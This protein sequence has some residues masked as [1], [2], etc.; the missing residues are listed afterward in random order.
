MLPRSLVDVSIIPPRVRYCVSGNSA[1][2]PTFQ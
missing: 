1:D 2:E